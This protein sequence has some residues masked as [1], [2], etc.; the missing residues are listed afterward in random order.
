MLDTV[1]KKV[2]KSVR[3]RNSASGVR[4]LLMSK[5]KDKVW[6][7]IRVIDVAKLAGS[8]ATWSVTLE[9]DGHT[10]QWYAYPLEND[11]EEI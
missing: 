7:N 1:V 8:K 10:I 3:F 11:I 9:Q 2:K 6:K 5:L 4:Q